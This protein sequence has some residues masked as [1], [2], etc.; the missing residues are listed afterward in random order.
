MT[1]G[2]LINQFR[3]EHNWTMEEFANKSGMSKSYISMLEKNENPRTKQ[4]ITPTMKTIS[5]VAKAMGI[6]VSALMNQLNEH[7]GKKNILD[8]LEILPV[9]EMVMVPVVGMVRAGFGGLA[10]EC[11]MG[12][13]TV[14]AKTLS[15]YDRNDFFYLKVKGDS[16]EP[17]LYEGDLVLVR[18]QSSIDS[19][20]YAVVAI[21]DEEGAIKIVQYDKTSITLVSQN[22]NYPPRVFRGPEVKRIR[23]IG[24]VIESK[25]KF[26]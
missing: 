11:D 9:G 21:D 18:R 1:I 17:R 22:H 2:A 7:N 6:S 23:V 3:Q 14:D 20:S 26:N 25:S 24:K 12:T 13:E 15:G 19:G 10:F 8:Q 5:A 4:P 16:M